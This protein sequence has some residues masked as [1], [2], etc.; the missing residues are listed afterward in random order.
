MLKGIFDKEGN[1]DEIQCNLKEGEGKNI[2]K[3]NKNIS[4]FQNI[5]DNFQLLI[6]SPTDTNL[7]IEG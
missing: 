2:K 4:V 1:I 7:I 5:L 3:N 6:I